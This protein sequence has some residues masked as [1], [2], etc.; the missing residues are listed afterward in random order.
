MATTAELEAAIWRAIGILEWEGDET[1]DRDLIE[2]ALRVLR[3]L[4]ALPADVYW[5]DPFAEV[6][7]SGVTG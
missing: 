6:E 5:P 2:S 4:A 7:P 1:S 3:P